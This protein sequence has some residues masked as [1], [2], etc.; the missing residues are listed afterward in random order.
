MTRDVACVREMRRVVLS[1][2]MDRVLPAFFLQEVV[3]TGAGK[4][5]ATIAND[6]V[7]YCDEATTMGRLAP[8]KCINLFNTSEFWHCQVKRSRLSSYSRK[9]NVSKGFVWASLQLP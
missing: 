5:V 7:G 3:R 1:W 6:I 2:L 8:H 4:R 9:P